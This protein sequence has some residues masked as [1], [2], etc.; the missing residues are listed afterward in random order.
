MKRFFVFIS[1][2]CLPRNFCEGY[3]LHSISLII[4]KLQV[5]ESV[6]ANS[7]NIVNCKKMNSFTLK[8]GLRLSKEGLERCKDHL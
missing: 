1:P 3:I 8:E 5:R 2:F 7:G 4:N 6:K